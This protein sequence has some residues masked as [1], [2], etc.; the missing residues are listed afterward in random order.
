[1]RGRVDL[2]GADGAT[3]GFCE[4]VFV[5]PLLGEGAGEVGL[6]GAETCACD[7][8]GTTAST[9]LAKPRRLPTT[10]KPRGALASER[11]GNRS[12]CN[13]NRVRVKRRIARRN[14]LENSVS[15]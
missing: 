5:E 9:P 13:M 14:A 6:T 4:S 11:I 7:I 8:R 15:F 12:E 3:P 2:P 10:S 1:M